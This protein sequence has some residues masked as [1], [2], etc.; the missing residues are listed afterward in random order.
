MFRCLE[1]PLLADSPLSRDDFVDFQEVVEYK[2]GKPEKVEPVNIVTEYLAED[3][4]ILAY[5]LWPGSSRRQ[6]G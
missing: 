3:S 5:K 4:S 6:G 2:T 1:R